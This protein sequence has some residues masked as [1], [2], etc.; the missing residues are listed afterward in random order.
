MTDARNVLFDISTEV[1]E[2]VPFGV[3]GDIYHIRGFEHMSKSEEAH[4]TALFAR[5]NRLSERLADSKK[6]D[7]AERIALA[8]YDLRME[9]LTSLTDLP[10]EVAERLPM[11]GQTKLMRAISRETG[12]G[13]DEDGDGGDEDLTP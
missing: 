10:R 3:D 6:R 5:Y 12:Q 13:D 2:P 1:A 8:M 9:L 7:E 11:S 4:V